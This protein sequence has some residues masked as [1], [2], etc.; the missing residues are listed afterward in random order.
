[1]RYAAG[2]GVPGDDREAAGWYRQAAERG[3]AAAQFNL[4]VRHGQGR[5]VEASDS[6][7]AWWYRQAAEQGYAAA[8]FNLGIR[9]AHGDGVPQDLVEAY[10]WVHLAAARTS[11]AQQ[12]QFTDALE[13]LAAQMT[14][15][16]VEQ[17]QQRIQQWSESF[18]RRSRK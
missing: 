13:E 16:Q 3:H 9:H 2:N 17:R 8:Q 14:P 5:G 10:W 18:E 6:L 15:A 12:S 11:G 1:V 4:G 7:A